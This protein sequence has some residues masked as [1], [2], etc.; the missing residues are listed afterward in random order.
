MKTVL[1]EEKKHYK[2]KPAGSNAYAFRPCSGA[3]D[4]V[5]SW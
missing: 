3:T 4:G 2:N 5:W 1:V